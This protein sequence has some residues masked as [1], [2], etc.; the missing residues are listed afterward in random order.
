[1]ERKKRR[2]CQSNH[3]REH[4]D[5]SVE[6]DTHAHQQHDTH[7]DP[8]RITTWTA[9][10]IW[11]NSSSRWTASD[12][13]YS[14]TVFLVVSS[15]IKN[16]STQMGKGRKRISRR[17]YAKRINNGGKERCV[18]ITVAIASRRAEPAPP[19]SI[20]SRATATR[21]PFASVGWDR[22]EPKDVSSVSKTGY[23]TGNRCFAGWL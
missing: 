18:S 19:H 4:Q 3:A 7:E 22:F 11:F 12:R 21:S 8:D 9:V 23:L 6:Q 20:T 17:R 10:D 1:M 13:A 16:P 15:T 2:H 5:Q 14:I